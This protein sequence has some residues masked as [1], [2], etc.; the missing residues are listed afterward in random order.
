LNPSSR[1]FIE[2]NAI[3]NT[4]NTSNT[5][6]TWHIWKTHISVKKQDI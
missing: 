1:S 3:V 6:L 5:H 4:S 2:V